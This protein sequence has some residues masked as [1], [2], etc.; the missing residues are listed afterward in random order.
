MKL[1]QR[2][3]AVPLACL[4]MAGAAMAE[5]EWT[6]APESY[7]CRS[8]SEVREIKT[9]VSAAARGDAQSGGLLCRVDYIKNG[10]TQ[11]IWSSRNSSS[12][13]GARASELVAKL[14]SGNF[15]CKPLH[16]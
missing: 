11:T 10:A 9:Y 6:N 5:E 12:Y 13:C 16:L 8:N 1:A 4:A 2:L 15:S 14:E 3:G 7:I